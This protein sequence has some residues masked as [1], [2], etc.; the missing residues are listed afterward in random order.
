[1]SSKRKEK[2][3][4]V[5]TQYSCLPPQ[6]QPIFLTPLR[7]IPKIKGAVTVNPSETT[8]TPPRA[9]SS[10]VTMEKGSPGVSNKIGPLA[11]DEL[12]K[13]SV[14][15]G[16]RVSS[17]NCDFCDSS[18]NCEKLDKSQFLIRL[19]KSSGTGGRRVSSKNCDFCDFSKNC[20]K[21]EI[22]LF[23]LKLIKSS[24]AGGRRASSKNCDFC[25]FYN[26][27][28]NCKKMG[29]IAVFAKIN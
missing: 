12:L 29:E 16:T 18:K 15:G 7:N 28:K 19:I 17:K 10:F 23:L 9:L 14:T 13:S 27:S 22:S 21:L 4:K 3:S 6:K 8:F 25:Y 1:M 5:L 26:F 20:E 24:V 11:Y 2:R